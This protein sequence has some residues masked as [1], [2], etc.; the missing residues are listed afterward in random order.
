MALE[1][2]LPP[3]SKRLRNPIVIE[4]LSAIALDAYLNANHKFTQQIINVRKEME[5]NRRKSLAIIP[6]I[7][8]RRVG[9]KTIDVLMGVQDIPSM[10]LLNRMTKILLPEGVSNRGTADEKFSVYARINS[11]VPIT[12]D[13]QAQAIEQYDELYQQLAPKRLM[14]IFPEGINGRD[15]YIRIMRPN[16]IE[17]AS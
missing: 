16:P 3:E 1:N 9:E 5:Q 14:S 13:F 7:E 17:E 6:D 8:I 2:F 10:Y 12:P 15:Q 11:S 4:S